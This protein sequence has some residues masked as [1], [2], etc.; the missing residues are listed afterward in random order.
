MK[1]KESTYYPEQKLIVTHVSGELDTQDIEDWRLSL[2]QIFEK[3][4]DH[5]RFKILVDLHGFRATNFEAHK[6]FRVIIPL[7]L[8]NCGWYIGYLRLFPET[9]ITIQSARGIHCVAAA[10]VHHDENKIANYATNYSMHNERFFT[11]S[12]VARNWIDSIAVPD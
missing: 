2:M 8:A 6:Q 5:S 12:Q 10:H 11:D 4:P 7:A 9:Q 3:L 1:R